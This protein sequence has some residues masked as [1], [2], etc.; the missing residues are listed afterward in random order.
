[1]DTVIPSH[2]PSRHLHAFHGCLQRRLFFFAAAALPVTGSSGIAS[3]KG[4]SWLSIFF[5]MPE[6][7]RYQSLGK[8]TK[9]SASNVSQ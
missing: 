9:P 4:I 3:D 5:A 2:T 1:M 7:R 8:L 6:S